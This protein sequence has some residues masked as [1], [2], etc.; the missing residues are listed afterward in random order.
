MPWFLIG[1]LQV[2]SIPCLYFSSLTSNLPVD[3]VGDENVMLLLIELDVVR[4]VRFGREHGQGTSRLTNDHHDQSDLVQ[5]TPGLELW[6]E[7]EL[8]QELCD[9]RGCCC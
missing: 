1:L 9:S 3:A 8:D 5:Q 2:H 6:E 4:K 7:I